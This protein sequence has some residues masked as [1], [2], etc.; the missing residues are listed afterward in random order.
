MSSKTRAD[1]VPV[2]GAVFYASA[3]AERSRVAGAPTIPR[4]VGL[5]ALFIVR[6]GR[7]ELLLFAEEEE[8]ERAP[9]ERFVATL[10][11]IGVAVTRED[12]S[13][14]YPSR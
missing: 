10:G 9:S 7:V 1:R 8:E 4:G 3:R 13:A 5:V 11:S 12:E 6:L 14:S 2:E